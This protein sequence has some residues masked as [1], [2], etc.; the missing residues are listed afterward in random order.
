VG[1][2]LVRAE[3]VDQLEAA[4]TLFCEYASLL[5]FDLAFQDFERE[6][7]ELPGQYAPPAGALFVALAGGVPAGC[8]GL[9]R[10][11]PETCEMKRL[12]VRPSV[13][14]RGLGRTLAE[15]AIDEA[16]RLGYA[17]MRLDT[18]PGMDHAWSLYH[19]LGFYEIDAYRFNPI[20]G[21]RYMERVLVGEKR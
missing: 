5:G 19:A 17:R 7:A 18:V 1:V 3:N 2:E 20:A 12:Y 15:A 13:R 10:L 11:D 4:R 6:L 21:A 14:G 8:V 9:R 16:L